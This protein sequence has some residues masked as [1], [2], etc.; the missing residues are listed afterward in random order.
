MKKDGGVS[1]T[2]A[3]WATFVIVMGAR[4]SLAPMTSTSIAALRISSSQPGPMSR[5]ASNKMHQRGLTPLMRSIVW[6]T[7][8][9]VYVTT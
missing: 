6:Q 9:T 8:S 1:I 3:P 7:A 5:I 2:F 4:R